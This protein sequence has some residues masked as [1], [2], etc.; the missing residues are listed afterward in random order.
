MY[1]YYLLYILYNVYIYIIYYILLYIVYIYVAKGA[2]HVLLK[3]RIFSTF[4]I[5][6]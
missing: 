6:V 4:T 5:S 3:G 1:I 2:Q